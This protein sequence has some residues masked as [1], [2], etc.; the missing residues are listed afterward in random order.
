MKIKIKIFML[1]INTLKI[2]FAI[3]QDFFSFFIKTVYILYFCVWIN[4]LII[5]VSP[6]LGQAEPAGEHAE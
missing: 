3:F 6:D 5:D 1:V 2:F 4:M